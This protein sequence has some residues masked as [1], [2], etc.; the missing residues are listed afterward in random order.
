[1]IGAGPAERR[2]YALA[3][4]H[5]I[6]AERLPLDDWADKVTELAGDA[7]THDPVEDLVVILQRRGVVTDRE[8]ASLYGDYLDEVA[9]AQR[10]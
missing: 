1:M 5:G 3:A 7:V 6:V 2:I 10:A 9:P 4:K 8:A